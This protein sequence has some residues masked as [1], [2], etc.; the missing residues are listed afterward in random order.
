M[1]ILFCI[2]NFYEQNSKTM[3]INSLEYLLKSSHGISNYSLDI[4]TPLTK[5]RADIKGKTS[6]SDFAQNIAS[7]AFKTQISTFEV[8]DYE[9]RRERNLSFTIITILGSL[10]LPQIASLYLEKN[11]NINGV[12]AQGIIK[13]GQTSHNEFVANGCMNGLQKV[14]FKYNIPI[15]TAIITAAEDEH[16]KARISKDGQ[17]LGA[18]SVRTL[19]D[20]IEI[21]KQIS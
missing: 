6:L 9:L 19:L 8:E 15:T 11:P 16:I 13:K 1:H 20:I 2:A 10:E 3:L 7:F 5:A 17:D 18:Q 4:K 14:F 12:V 21:K